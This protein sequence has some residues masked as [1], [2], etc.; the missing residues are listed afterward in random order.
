M[1][2]EY[3]AMGKVTQETQA[4]GATT[5]YGYD[6]GGR[7]IS[8]T[9]ASGSNVRAELDAMGQAVAIID[10]IGNRIE[11]EFDASGRITSATG[12]DGGNVNIEY[13]DAGKPIKTT[14]P[15]GSNVRVSYDAAGRVTQA[16]DQLGRVTSFAYD[17]VGNVVAVTDALGGA[18]TY[19]YDELGN[20]T[21]HVDARGKVTKFEYSNLGKIIKTTLPM[22]MAE[23][24]EYDGRGV[25]TARTNFNGDMTTYVT[26]SNHRLLSQTLPDGA[27]VT[28]SYTP[29]GKISAVTDTLGVTTYE[30]DPDTSRLVKQTMPD[31]RTVQYAYDSLGRKTGVRTSAGTTVYIYDEFS[32]V[33]RVRDPEG[34]F[35]DYEYNAVGKMTK[36]TYPNGN[37]ASADYDILGR[38]TSVL[39]RDASSA[40]LAASTYEYD[41][42]GNV[43][44]VT[45]LAGRKV[46][47]SYDALNRLTQEK[48]TDPV[49]GDEIISY[50]YDAVGNRLSRI[51]ASGVANYTYDDND[52][53]LDDGTY[54]YTYDANGNLLTQTGT[55][56]AVEY[57]YEAHNR[58]VKATVDFADTP[59]VIEYDYT[60]GVRMRRTVDGSEVIN[61]LY[62]MAAPF[63]QV[64][65]ESDGQ[66]ERIADYVVGNGLI[67]RDDGQDISYYYRDGTESTRQLTD[68]LGTVTDAYNYDAFGRLRDH[69]G[70]SDNEFLFAG[71]QLDSTAGIYYN[72]ARYLDPNLGRFLSRDP[73]PGNPEKPLTFHPYSYVENNPLVNLDPSGQFTLANIAITVAIIG[74][75]S[76]INTT[77][78]CVGAHPFM[79]GTSTDSTEDLLTKNPRALDNFSGHWIQMTSNGHFDIGPATLAKQFTV[80]RALGIPVAT[81]HEEL[82]GELN[83]LPIVPVI[84]RNIWRVVP[85]IRNNLMHLAYISS[86]MMPASAVA[87]AFATALNQTLYEIMVTYS[88]G[89]M[90]PNSEVV[91]AGIGLS[92]GLSVVHNTRDSSLLDGLA[93]GSG[94]Q[95]DMPG[96][97]GIYLSVELGFDLGVNMEPTAILRGQQSLFNGLVTMPSVSASGMIG[98]NAGGPSWNIFAYWATKM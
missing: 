66:G 78:V 37:T 53:L 24:Y 93:V 72:R 13:N 82:V 3:D 18:T 87:S 34:R 15:D 95:A 26:D 6:A 42:V 62:D 84:G 12:S 23:T 21:R 92:W 27:T 71:E 41:L 33:K 17:V 77:M 16:T 88:S 7:I 43:T 50:T 2:I 5:A 25:L 69:A 36:V 14:L 48:I 22:G 55:S 58:L 57:Q 70:S 54:T 19:E 10:P 52:R 61:Y 86:G 49:H 8:A 31:S 91:Q 79:I 39:H 46:D 45:E 89:A 76:T 96:S 47:Y 60:E 28:Y 80:S 40:L 65:L 1:T 94:I 63:P 29:D 75:L 83:I 67:R 74:A 59:T 56:H 38:L 9:S 44:R 98:A 64:I 73:A 90:M 68:Q 81:R 11:R 85:Y 4:N 97:G 32:R 35:T 30:Y 20:M 51:D